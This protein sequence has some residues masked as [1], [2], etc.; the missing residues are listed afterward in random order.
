M[1][2]MNKKEEEIQGSRDHPQMM[3]E[4]PREVAIKVWA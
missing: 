3:E 2:L 1:S 4:L